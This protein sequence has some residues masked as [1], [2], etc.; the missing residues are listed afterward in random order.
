[1]PPY[2]YGAFKLAMYIASLCFIVEQTGISTAL[3]PYY[4]PFR[5]YHSAETYSPTKSDPVQ[6]VI[7]VRLQTWNDMYQTAFTQSQRQNTNDSNH[8]GYVS[9]VL[10]A[11][12]VNILGVVH[13]VQLTANASSILEFAYKISAAEPQR[14]KSA[15][16]DR[17]YWL[18]T[19]TGYNKLD[20]IWRAFVMFLLCH[21]YVMNRAHVAIPAIPLIGGA[22]FYGWHF[23]VKTLRKI[24]TLSKNLSIAENSVA[25][26]AS[27][28]ALTEEKATRAEE[29]KEELGRNYAEAMIFKGEVFCARWDSMCD[30]NSGE[31]ASTNELKMALDEAEHARKSQGKAEKAR[32]DSEDAEK[33]ANEALDAAHKEKERL[34]DVATT[35]QT[36]IDE[37]HQASLL[38]KRNKTSLENEIEGVKISSSTAVEKAQKKLNQEIEV[39]KSDR[40]ERDDKLKKQNETTVKLRKQLDELSPKG[41]ERLKMQLEEEER[42][43]K[44]AEEKTKDLETEMAKAEKAR[45]SAKAD[46]VRELEAE[47]KKAQEGWIAVKR[48]LDEIVAE[49]KKREEEASDLL[50][51]RVSESEKKIEEAKEG[52]K[53][54]EK[55]L[56]ETVAEQ[57]KKMEEVRDVREEQARAEKAE[58]KKMEEVRDGQARAEKAEQQKTKEAR[59]MLVEEERTAATAQIQVLKGELEQHKIK[60]EQTEQNH[61]HTLNKIQAQLDETNKKKIEQED[62]MINM[63]ELVNVEIAAKDARIAELESLLRAKAP[64]SL[65]WDG[66]DSTATD[67]DEPQPRPAV[68]LPPSA[69][70]G[71]DS[72][73]AA[74]EGSASKIDEDEFQ[75]KGAGAASMNNTK[76]INHGHDSLSSHPSTASTPLCGNC[77][78][79]HK[80]PCRWIKPP[81]C[82]DCGKNHEGQCMKWCGLCKDYLRN[83]P[84]S[85]KAGAS[86]RAAN[87]ASPTYQDDQLPATGPI[88]A[89]NASRFSATHLGGY[90]EHRYTR[91]GQAPFRP[92]RGGFVPIRGAQ[93]HG[94]S[95]GRGVDRGGPGE[96][97]APLSAAESFQRQHGGRGQ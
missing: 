80:P 19:S 76:P 89:S 31:D 70:D 27:Q 49:N 78:R 1:M 87:P 60:A 72:G 71:Y 44:A 86:S 59:D 7:P 23:R 24:M 10:A 75:I 92:S 5:P 83:C 43:R 45:K 51:N 38:L 37:M 74:S 93:R 17:W 48:T 4:E 33:K 42:A 20:R 11:E 32:Q 29:A 28:V 16:F 68:K 56:G 35:Q 15:C 88:P 69:S 58:Q 65:D 82:F 21:D 91:P 63:S 67:S 36:T 6:V 94:P 26:L 22:M 97:R 8:T 46:K 62:E 40:K 50:A 90:G 96:H 64:P 9:S 95:A 84:H 61:S 54:A 2:I 47:V 81:Y 13:E 77:R 3:A 66:A 52:R 85:K 53:T 55:K 39:L 18:R 25:F 30:A 12:T 34:S 57:Q 79:V 73:D 41:V 14:I